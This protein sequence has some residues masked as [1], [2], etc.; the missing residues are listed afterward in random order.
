MYRWADFPCTVI[1]LTGVPSIPEGP[2]GP[3][4]P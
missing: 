2:G 3:G 4:G 1:L